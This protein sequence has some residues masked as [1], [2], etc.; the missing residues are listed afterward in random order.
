MDSIS[1]DGYLDLKYI[2]NVEAT[3]EELEKHLWFLA[4]AKKRDHKKLGKELDLFVFNV[5]QGGEM[6]GVNGMERVCTE[7]GIKTVPIVSRSFIPSKE[8]G[9]GK[10]VKEVVD[11]MVKLSQGD[12]RLLKRKR[13]GIVVRLCSDPRVSFKVINPY[14]LL[15]EKD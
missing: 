3:K 4:E 2:T 11:F 13:E 6:L 5:F 10:E 12:S 15:D 9:E 8:I 14:F 7:L 1:V